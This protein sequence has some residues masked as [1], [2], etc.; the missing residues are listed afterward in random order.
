MVKI[1]TARHKWSGHIPSGVAFGIGIY[2][3]PAFTIPQALGGFAHFISKRYF[4]TA[5]LPVITAA[6]ALVLGD[7]LV[8]MLFMVLQSFENQLS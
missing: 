5:E 1:L 7:T 8:N 6:I 3:L 4:R 2:I